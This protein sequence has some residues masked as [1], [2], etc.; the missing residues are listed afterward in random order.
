MLRVSGKELKIR[1]ERSAKP[2]DIRTRSFLGAASAMGK[3]KET[4]SNL[5]RLEALAPC[6]EMTAGRCRSPSTTVPLAHVRLDPYP[7]REA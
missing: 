2:S 3:I 6:V 5:V 4:P 1:D 7:F